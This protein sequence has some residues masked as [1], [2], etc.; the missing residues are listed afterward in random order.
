MGKEENNIL[1][2]RGPSAKGRGKLTGHER[3]VRR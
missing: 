2:Q 3:Q 1:D